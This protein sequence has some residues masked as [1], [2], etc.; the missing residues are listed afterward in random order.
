MIE[1]SGDYSEGAHPRLLNRLVETNMEQT[2]GYG[3]DR[4]CA[5]AVKTIRKACQNDDVDVHMVVGG[6]LA[7]TIAIAAALRPH[8]G[9][10]AP[11]S[12]HINV[13][14]TG[15][16]EAA[17]HK[18]LTIPGENGKITAAQIDKVCEEY[19][20]NNGNVHVVQPKMV[21]LTH[22]TEYGTIYGRKE[23]QVISDV[24]RK[25]DLYL[26]ID[27]ARIGYGVAAVDSDMDLPFIAK[28][29]DV[30]CIGGSKQGAFFG[31]AVVVK[32]KYIADGFRQVMKQRG[33]LLAKGRLLGIQFHE[34]LVD[35]L[36]FELSR[37]A[38]KMAASIRGCLQA[39]G[40]KFFVENTTNL[41]F[42]ILP[43]NLYGELSKK[44]SLTYCGRHD[45]KSSIVRIAT[46]WATTERNVQLLNSDISAIM[47]R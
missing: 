42:P 8:Q 27:G 2:F 44:Y 18:I 17:G 35:G 46:S 9:V 10:I 47:Q 36:Y 15:S 28:C 16:I 3:R 6:T 4:Y 24:C 38:N 39:N 32:N 23:L 25:R 41:L 7:N 22:A 29:C 45:D 13:Q 43:D 20:E 26:Y 40:I 37:H 31:E 19:L 34:L 21:C 30:F 11:V 33:G 14:E 5:E 12:A 1:F